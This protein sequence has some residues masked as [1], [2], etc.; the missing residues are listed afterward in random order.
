MPVL[1]APVGRATVIVGRR[2]REP[3]KLGI[4]MPLG[5]PSVEPAVA[6]TRLGVVAGTSRVLGRAPRVR[7]RVVIVAPTGARMDRPDLRAHLR[8]FVFWTEVRCPRSVSVVLG[9]VSV[10]RV[11]WGSSL[12][13]GED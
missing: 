10:L 9:S 4:G 8:P 5:V 13:L 11:G 7:T 1:G 2:P 3:T 12:P 6:T